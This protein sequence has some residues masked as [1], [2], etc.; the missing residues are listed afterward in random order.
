M[1]LTFHIIYTPNTF[2][3]FHRFLDGLLRW[4]GVGLRLVANGCPPEETEA[5]RDYVAG[6][7]R[8]QYVQIAADTIMTHADA[9]NLLQEQEQ[10]EYF[11]FMDPDI[12]VTGDFMPW[13]TAALAENDAIFTGAP[14]WADDD[15]L[16]LP[17]EGHAMPGRFHRTRAGLC[18]GGT[19]FAVYRNQCLAEIRRRY[20]IGFERLKW[21]EIPFRF[22]RRIGRLGL[23]RRKYD[24]GKV[25]NLLLLS[26]NRALRWL[27]LPDMYHVGGASVFN[28]RIGGMADILS[29]LNAERIQQ[30]LPGEAGL[31]LW[32][33]MWSAEGRDA[34]Y[35][36]LTD[37]EALAVLPRPQNLRFVVSRQ[38]SRWLEA[39]MNGRPAPPRTKLNQ[40]HI[41]QRLDALLAG[42]DELFDDSD[43]PAPSP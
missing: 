23:K 40:P 3:L 41:D 43:A 4:S 33:K 25:L 1:V 14:I 26:E 34:L 31:A 19:Y 18:L 32:E 10:S 27:D 7:S 9:L 2:F 30:R 42:I 8:L 35:E 20:G 16:V 24:T 37:A 29:A 12:L 11:S 39:R 13:I 6:R 17:E 15:D 28:A 5:M 36:N 21:D 38:V 22:R